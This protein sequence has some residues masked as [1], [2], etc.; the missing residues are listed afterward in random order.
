MKG[1]RKKINTGFVVLIVMLLFSGVVA[2]FEL[3]RL[4]RRTEALLDSSTLNIE[5]SKRMLD[6][7]EQ[8]NSSLLQMIV[9]QRTEYDS[10]FL[11]GARR[12]DAALAEAAAIDEIQTDL[13]SIV[14]ARDRYRS[15]VSD[16]FNDQMNTDVAW[17]VGMYKTTYNQLTTAIKEYMTGS[18]FSLVSRA[19]Q[20]ENN[21]Y[22]AIMPG[23]ITLVAAILIILIFMFLIELYFTRPV[24]KTE[25]ALR[26]YL[27]HGIPFRVTVEGRDEVAML[28]DDIED[29]ITA[30]K[31]KKAE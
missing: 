17:F 27:K 8:Q 25:Q 30:H 20:L 11:D 21:A 7:V 9:L 23:I 29:L 14:M 13:D 26:G 15:L 19:S 2:F 24:V 18:Q 28:K 4:S 31:A 10:L 1:I 16:F 12:F 5:L 22:R 6:A 3:G